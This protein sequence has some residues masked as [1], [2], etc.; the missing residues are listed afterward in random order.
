M[1]DIS[2]QD[3]N[4]ERLGGG[5]GEQPPARIGLDHVAKCLQLFDNGLAFAGLVVGKEDAVGHGLSALRESVATPQTLM[6][7]LKVER[8]RGCYP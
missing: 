7:S 5:A 1:R 6:C 8:L 4:P 2:P 3:S